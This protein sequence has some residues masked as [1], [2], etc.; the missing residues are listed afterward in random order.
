MKTDGITITHPDK[1]MFFEAKITKHE[2]VEYYQRIADY[3][4]PWIKKRP[5]TLKRFPHGIAENGFFNKH[6]PDY[7]PDFIER[8]T[9]PMEKKGSKMQMVGVNASR[10]LVYLAEQNTI[11][12]HMA[13]ST[14]DTI[15]QPDQMIFDLDPSDDDFEKV[16]TIA[17]CLKTIFDQQNIPSFVKTTG[18]R[19][20][21]V[22]VPILIEKDFNEVKACAK[23]IAELLHH[24]CPELTTLEH[25]KEK[26]Q[27][28]VFIDYLR[29]E[30]AMTVTAPYALRAH[31]NAPVATPIDWDELQDKSLKPH[32]YHLKNIFQRLGQK[33]D[34]WA[35]FDQKKIP[36]KSLSQIDNGFA[37]LKKR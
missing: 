6:A 35:G 26:R 34:P 18:S 8:F 9:V 10:D 24:T 3:I 7:F 16:R 31:A 33:P 13:L 12:L 19:G 32:S 11:E 17:F 27:N 2:M 23:Q 5:L 21:H 37:R 29:N 4:L 22:H 25:R 28:K 14:I 36:F 30:Y 20:V 15:K 1:M